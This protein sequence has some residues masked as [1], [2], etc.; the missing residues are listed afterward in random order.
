MPCVYVETSQFKDIL[1]ALPELPPHNWLITDL[2][3]YDNRG[4][5]GCEKLGR[6]RTVSDR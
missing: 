1:A 6:T 4:W 3:C 5:D 2:E